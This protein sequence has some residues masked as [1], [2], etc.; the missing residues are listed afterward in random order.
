MRPVLRRMSIALP[1]ALA[2]TAWAN[3]TNYQNYL[4]GERALGLG[5]A[6]CALADDASGAFYNP[7]GVARVG[8]SSLSGSLNIYGIERQKRDRGYTDQFPVP[9]DPQDHE[10]VSVDLEDTHVATLPTTVALVRKLGP[11]M[12]DG[13]QAHAVGFAT[14]LPYSSAFEADQVVRGVR[15]PSQGHILIEESDKTLWMGPFYAVRLN[16]RLSL[17]AALHYSY[18]T[19]KRRLSRAWEQEISDEDPTTPDPSAKFSLEEAALDYTSAELFAR[20]GARLDVGR[21]WSL[22]LAVTTPTA[23]L[24]GQ[25]RLFSQTVSAEVPPD[26]PGLAFYTPEEESGLKTRNPEPVSVRAGAAWQRERGL[27]AA[28]VTFHAPEEFDPVERGTPT[29]VVGLVHV[30]PVKRNP[31]VNVNLGGQYDFFDRMPVRAGFLTNFSSAPEVEA[32]D[33]QQLS[34]VN[35]YGVTA[36]IGYAPEDYE[37][38][39][40]VLYAFGSG[41]AS[42]VDKAA[43]ANEQFQPAPLRDDFVYFYVSGAEKALGKVVKKLVGGS[44]KE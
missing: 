20:V 36:S 37:V 15:S 24:H 25:G 27:V 26:A 1:V 7:A 19:V 28:D 23:H 21:G 8:S 34:H 31:V 30:T 6:F 41:Q 32:T 9:P 11:K 44:S 4:V 43:P 12:A 14:Y 18:R 40:G 39:L 29:A 16:E 3:D 13:V 17:G 2:A 33:H 35:M 10:N 5:G 38:S 42:A 22:G